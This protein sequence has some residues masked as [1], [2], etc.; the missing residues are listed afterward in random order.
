[1]AAVTTAGL[2]LIMEIT[3]KAD[4]LERGSR[5][6]NFL[7]R[8]LN[9]WS[10]IQKGKHPRY[11]FGSDRFANVEGVLFE[12]AQNA[13]DAEVETMQGFVGGNCE[14]IADN[15]QLDPHRVKSWMRT[16]RQLRATA[17]KG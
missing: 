10:L 15:L 12:Y 9:E 14:V 8:L 1:M 4:Q 7:M 3:E 2:V 16:I 13:T 17:E 6:E 5:I 11:S